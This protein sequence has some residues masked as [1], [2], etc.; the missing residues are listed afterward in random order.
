MPATRPDVV[1]PELARYI[2]AHS[3]RPDA[4]QERLMTVTEQRTG[5]AS[6]M[7][8]GGDQ[9]TMFEMLARSMQVHDAIEIG[10]FTGYSALSIARGMQPGGRLI[11][12]DVSEEWTAI[13]REHWQIAGVDDRIE[14]RIGPALQ[15]IAELPDEQ[16]F[17][18]VFIDAD[19]PNYANYFEALV[20]RL[21]PT[22]L[23]LV[24]NTLWS[25]E[26]IDEHATDAI[27]VALQ[28]FNDQVVADPRVRCVILPV[29]DGVTMI[30][31]AS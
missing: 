3:S 29:G 16:L 2:A 6:T 1:D 20:P 27:T 25:G 21:R 10:T 9:G 17:D 12:C 7:Q 13:A 30:Q 5:G 31:L 23:M 14:L 22:G 15:T 19:K 18:L 24:D 4:V 8:I 11:C 26:V 28:A